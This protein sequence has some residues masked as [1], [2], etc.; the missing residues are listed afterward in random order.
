FLGHG[1]GASRLNG[2]GMLSRPFVDR[3]P[4]LKG[5]GPRKHGTQPMSGQWKRSRVSYSGTG[6]RKGQSTRKAP[7][8]PPR[9]SSTLPCD[10]AE[11][12][13]EFLDPLLELCVLVAGILG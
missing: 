10:F 7:P 2:G 5:T 3:V 8:T 13:A 1:R 4:S 11:R 9:H 12:V 6:N